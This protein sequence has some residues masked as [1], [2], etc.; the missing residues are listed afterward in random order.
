M[1]CF[2]CGAV[3]HVRLSCHVSAV[4]GPSGSEAQANSNVNQTVLNTEDVGNDK[5]NLTEDVKNGEGIPTESVG[6]DK[7]LSDEYE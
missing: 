4:A 7:E 2:E 1:R 5:E 3:G 6:K